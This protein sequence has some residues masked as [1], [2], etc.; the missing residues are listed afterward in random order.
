MPFRL[1][2]AGVNVAY[3]EKLEARRSEI[4]ATLARI[5][6]EYLTT[7]EPC[8]PEE[9]R[10]MCANLEAERDGLDRQVAWYNRRTGW[11]WP[12]DPAWTD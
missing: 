10:S 7:D 1:N 11:T 2:Q 6:E 12:A 9:Y 4:A 3:V 5:T 8:A